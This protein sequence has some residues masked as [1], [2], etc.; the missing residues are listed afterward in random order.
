MLR[1]H[2]LTVGAKFLGARIKIVRTFH[3]LDQFN[4]KMKPL[5][6]LYRWQTD[7]FIA[8]SEMMKDV[9]LE[10]NFKR[11][12]VVIYNG[13]PKVEATKHNKAIGYLGRIA[14]EKGILRF[15]EENKERL[16]GSLK[17]YIAGEGEDLKNLSVLVKEEK[18][19]V[20]LMGF[21]ARV[22]KFFEKIQVLVL[23]TEA[24]STLPL[25]VI[26]GFSCGVPVVTFDIKPLSSLIR[27]EYGLLLP[28]RDYIGM[29]E[30]VEGLLDEDR[31]L[32]RLSEE[33]KSEYINNYP[34]EKM[35]SKTDT[36]Y[37]SLFKN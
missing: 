28:K 8:V 22:E 2:S 9:L 13:V 18:L 11:K 1:E 27:S 35:W 30:A 4:L 10:N 36:L 6:W 16:K 37:K 34:I 24:E 7:A 23:P 25:A 3:R 26:E 15:V 12:V 31:K 17:L 14:P 29:G 20:E 19:N 32:E 21:M 5:L 33:A